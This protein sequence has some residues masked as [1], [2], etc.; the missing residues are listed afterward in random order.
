MK[1]IIERAAPAVAALALFAS[2]NAHAVDT[3]DATSNLLSINAIAVN[4]VNYQNVTATVR[5]FTLLGV[6]SGFPGGDSFNPATNLLTLGSVLFQGSTYNNVRVQLNTYTLL[7]VSLA[8]TGPDTSSPGTPTAPVTPTP[9]P[10]PAPSA[11]SGTLTAANTCGLANFQSDLMALINQARA[12]SRT[13]GSTVYPTAA[14]LAWN[15]K[16]FDA[17]AGHSADMATQN[18]FSHTSL[19]GRTFDQRITAAGYGWSS[20]AENIAAGQTSAASVMSAWMASAGHCSNIM[21][22]SLT[23]VGVACVS[24]SSSTYHTYWT[25]DLGRP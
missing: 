19:D 10:T 2:F 13:C 11:P 25:M 4:G 12:S 22:S 9:A 14:P 6:D 21:N 20:I 8:P 23:E 5:S 15:G 3:F 18:Y 24:S 1:K 16:L 17:A 7:T